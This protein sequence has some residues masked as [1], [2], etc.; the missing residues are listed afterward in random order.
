MRLSPALQTHPS[1]GL[2]GFAEQENDKMAD[3]ERA[4]EAVEKRLKAGRFIES[5]KAI[6]LGKVEDNYRRVKDGDQAQ[7]MFFATSLPLAGSIIQLGTTAE[8]FRR[9]NEWVRES[10]PDADPVAILST[11]T[12]IY[13]VNK[14][15][16]E[17]T[18][19]DDDEKKII[20]NE[21]AEL[22]QSAVNYA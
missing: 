7:L 1:R 12:L 8:D 3:L 6:I 11:L 20:W 16:D 22:V 18:A 19:S 14:G 5:H 13:V 4:A 9:A 2:E 15:W 17:A 10:L 21:M